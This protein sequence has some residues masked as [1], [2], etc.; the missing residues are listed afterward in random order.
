MSLRLK[1]RWAPHAKLL[2]ALFVI[3]ELLGQK[4]SRLIREGE[5]VAYFLIDCF[6][7]L[8]K[9]ISIILI[10]SY[11]TTLFSRLGGFLYRLSGEQRENISEL[12]Q[13][14]R[15]TTEHMH[16]QLQSYFLLSDYDLLSV[17]FCGF[18]R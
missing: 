5:A 4:T 18:L 2:H 7:Y 13:S 9:Q 8:A 16:S 14:L 12:L 3:V 15:E 6:G 10:E 17:F 11:N 1:L